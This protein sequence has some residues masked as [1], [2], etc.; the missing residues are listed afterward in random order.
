MFVVSRWEDP[1]ENYALIAEH[2]S[3]FDLNDMRTFKLYR[4]VED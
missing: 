4:R 2:S 3:P 1:G